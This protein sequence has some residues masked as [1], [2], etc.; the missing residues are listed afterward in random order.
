M[1][2][3]EGCPATMLSIKDALEVLE[4][5][6]KLLILF[7]LSSGPKRFKQISKEV[8]GITDKMLSKELKSL[9]ANQLV[10][11]E[12]HDT[13][14]PSVEYSITE[15]GMSLEKVLDELHYWGLAHRKKIIGK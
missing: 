9:E 13:F 2:T 1:L 4:G 10:K 11:R 8:G 6:W 15:H 5:R 7:S 12:T 3:R 14:P